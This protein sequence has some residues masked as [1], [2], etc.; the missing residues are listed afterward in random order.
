MLSSVMSH[1]RS[2]RY[3]M[4]HKCSPEV[5][6]IDVT[7]WVVWI[8]SDV[9]ILQWVCRHC[10]R[11]SYLQ[12]TES[13]KVWLLRQNWESVCIVRLPI[14]LRI[15]PFSKDCSNF[16]MRIYHE[17]ICLVWNFHRIWYSDKLNTEPTNWLS[18]YNN[19]NGYENNFVFL[20][21]LIVATSSKIL[22]RYGR[23]I[24][25]GIMQFFA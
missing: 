25:S 23:S 20:C 10:M 2:C 24:D 1:D 5:W 18:L 13:Q 16:N 15:N 7:C 17:F 4:D 9:S 21:L 8:L 12:Q 11:A 22:D 14:A 19:L 6:V 3:P